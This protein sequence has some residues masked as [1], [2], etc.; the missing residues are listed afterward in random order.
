MA[1]FTTI[2]DSL[3]SMPLTSISLLDD[4]LLTSFL[5]KLVLRL[6]FFYK[7][8]ETKIVQTVH[9]AAFCTVCNVFSIYLMNKLTIHCD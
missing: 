1:C 3:E 7:R 9:I 5:L 4:M 6:V 8:V 2:T